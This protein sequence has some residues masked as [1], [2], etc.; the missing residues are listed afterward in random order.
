[1]KYSQLDAML[2]ESGFDPD[3]VDHLKAALN[4]LAE[5]ADEAPGP[6]TEL[7]ALLGEK[8]SDGA[9]LHAVP[10]RAQP[11]RSRGVVV[12]AVVLAL[13]GVG[14]TGLS[15]AANTL[16]SPWQH[17]VSDFSRRYLPFDFPQPTV[18]LPH[19]APVPLGSNDPDPDAEA[20]GSVGELLVQRP[21]RS[22]E[23]SRSLTRTRSAAQGAR[24]SIARHAGR[25][26]HEDDSTPAARSVSEPQASESPSASPSSSGSPGAK[27]SSDSRGTPRPAVSGP[28][29]S[30]FAPSKPAG[31]AGPRNPGAPSGG[32]YHLLTPGPLPAKGPVN[33]P[34]EADPG[35]GTDQ[36]APG[37][38]DGDSLP[39]SPE[40]SAGS[41]DTGPVVEG[42]APDSG[43][44]GHGDAPDN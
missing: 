33:G 6:S 3:D 20:A 35:S 24:P 5:L 9:T 44:T 32:K 41:I 28:V 1:V 34:V 27:P 11:R 25:M 18:Q 37:E 10:T 13:S 29:R 42:V 19:L 23:F 14:A 17:E 40:P 7:L 43:S 12:G 8:S 39:E 38:G 4:P 21:D 26:H 36:P 31:V 22:D 15:A 30:S 2:A 16:P